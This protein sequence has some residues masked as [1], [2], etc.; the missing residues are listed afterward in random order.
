M[1][2]KFPEDQGFVPYGTKYLMQ[3]IFLPILC[4]YG[5]NLSNYANGIK[6]LIIKHLQTVKG[7]PLLLFK[8]R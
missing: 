1:G 5:I 7:K 4:T 3:I 8:R 6:K 2:R